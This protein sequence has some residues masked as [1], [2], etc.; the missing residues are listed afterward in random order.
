MFGKKISQQYVSFMFLFILWIF[1]N[2]TIE[3]S[4]LSTAKQ[5]QYRE[6][7]LIQWFGK[8]KVVWNYFESGL[9]LY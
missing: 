3:A 9:E 2:S 5:I 8:N 7:C 1:E 4:K 6:H